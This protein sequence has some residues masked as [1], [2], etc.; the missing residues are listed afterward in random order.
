ML[1][2]GMAAGCCSLVHLL[3]HSRALQL[4]DVFIL[5][6]GAAVIITCRFALDVAVL[7]DS[8]CRS[9]ALQS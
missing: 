7:L 5:Q 1:Q 6:Q 3:S 2:Q 8:A 4:D 9:S